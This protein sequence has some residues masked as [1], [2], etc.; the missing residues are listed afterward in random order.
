[1]HADNG[2]MHASLRYLALPLYAHGSV[3]LEFSQNSTKFQ[4]LL[5]IYSFRP[6]VCPSVR[7]QDVGHL[8]RRPM[9]LFALFMF[10]VG[11]VLSGAAQ[12]MWW[13]IV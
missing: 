10:A 8:G 11:S 2:F 12:S 7:R 6:S 13:L 3:S 4:Q 5:Q 1:M 9:F